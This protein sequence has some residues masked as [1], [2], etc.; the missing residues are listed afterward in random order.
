MKYLAA[1]FMV[2]DHIGAVLYPN[3]IIFRI[4]GRL[5]MPIFA[6]GIAMGFVHTS[7]L[8]KYII[9]LGIFTLV[10]QPF[11]ILMEYSAYGRS[12]GTN[13][14]ATFLIACLILTLITRKINLIKG[15]IKNR[16]INI[17]NQVIKVV[18]I[19]GL[20][21]LSEVLRCD[22]GIYGVMVV[23]S[24]YY[25]ISRSDDKKGYIWFAIVTLINGG[26]LQLFSLISIIFL[27]YAKNKTR[28]MPRYFLYVF[29]PAHML[30]IVLI[31]MLLN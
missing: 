11:F 5:A 13:I 9:R 22:Y 4:I 28:Y 18:L 27:P 26:V 6:Y 8:K 31:D 10:S 25:G 30:C 21:V 2:I 17:A 23:L 7:S 1:L 16:N 19:F 14:G 15:D 24:F 29:Y 20:L 3:E 12:V